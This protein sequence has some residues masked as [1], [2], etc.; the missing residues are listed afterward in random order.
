MGRSVHGVLIRTEN[1]LGLLK[2]N[3][4]VIPKRICAS[5]Q[6]FFDELISI[7]NDSEEFKYSYTT[8]EMGDRALQIDFEEYRKLSPKGFEAEGNH[9]L[10]LNWAEAYR[11]PFK[12]SVFLYLYFTV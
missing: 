2:E 3:C 8:Y 6:T 11:D 10:L 12:P 7:G 4:V 5:S 1:E 9:E